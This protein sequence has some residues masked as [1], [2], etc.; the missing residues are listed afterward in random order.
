MSSEKTLQGLSRL[1]IQIIVC[2]HSH[3]ICVYFL[4]VPHLSGLFY[5]VICVSA[6][7][8]SNCESLHTVLR[9]LT[10]QVL[11]LFTQ[12]APYVRIKTQCKGFPY[13]LLK[14]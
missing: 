11:R 3:T 5:P 2:A 4:R 10:D 8:V 12:L 14:F 6:A 9:E 13:S 7:D 1:W